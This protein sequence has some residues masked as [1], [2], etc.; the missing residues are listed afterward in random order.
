[1]KEVQTSK[2]DI[3]Y[4]TYLVVD[5]LINNKLS[6]QTVV[7]LIVSCLLVFCSVYF[8]LVKGSLPVDVVIIPFILVK[9]IT[10]ETL[11][12]AL[13]FVACHSN[14]VM[15]SFHSVLACLHLSHRNGCWIPFYH[16]KHWFAGI[17][18][19][20][21]LCYLEPKFRC[22]ISYWLMN[23]LN[24]NDFTLLQ[25]P[26]KATRGLSLVLLL[27]GDWFYVWCLTPN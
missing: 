5:K 24:A 11:N 10:C 4:F 7:C 27:Y 12:K 21:K 1:M 6:W 2:L 8:F 13:E 23:M 14:F 9:F 19:D 20:Y 17:Q 16:L 22:F 15:V 3:F 18:I 25:K 26:N